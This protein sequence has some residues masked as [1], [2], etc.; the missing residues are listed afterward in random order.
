[1]KKIYFL[2]VILIINITFLSAQ[3]FTSDYLLSDE[4][5]NSISNAVDGI[6][7]ITSSIISDTFVPMTHSE[8]GDFY[9]SVVPAYCDVDVVS[10]SDNWKGDNLRVYA[11]GAGAGYALNDS[12]IIYGIASEIQINGKV[13]TEGYS[14]NTEYTMAGI[15]SGLGYELIKD[16]S[17]LSIPVFAGIYI[18]NYNT[19]VDLDIDAVSTAIDTYEGTLGGAWT[20]SNEKTNVEGNGTIYGITLAVAF[21]YKFNNNKKI[22][23]YILYSRNLSNAEID[24]SVSAT[25]T[26]PIPAQYSDS[27]SPVST[28]ISDLEAT[29]FGLNMSYEATDKLDF[30]LSVGGLL[31]STSGFYNDTFLDGLG[32]TTIAM[33]VTY[34]N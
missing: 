25:F 18:Q 24:T 31:S 13:Y 32:L 26:S 4:I 28:E 29:M 19:T 8:K 17:K 27:T 1:M 5:Q 2:I 6:I 23:P 12:L 22:T 14:G 7:N 3:T 9:I 16:N 11:L 30:S 15:C 21:S 33:A 10:E 20:I 34:K